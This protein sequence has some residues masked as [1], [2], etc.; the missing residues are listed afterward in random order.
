MPTPPTSLDKTA[1][2][3]DEFEAQI[4]VCEPIFNDYGGHIRFNGPIETIKCHEDNSLV[5]ELLG[6]PGKGRI[7][8]VDA[9]GSMR[10]AMLGDILAQKGVDNG[11]AG[12]LMY[13]CIRD[14]KE[15]SAMPIGVKALATI[16]KKSVKKG[17][18]ES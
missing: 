3:Y 17:V 15:I 13:G 11:W 6:Q 4:Q 7:L 9:G 12:V 18:G 1:D 10:C 8:V 2:I 16:P 14:A 5:R